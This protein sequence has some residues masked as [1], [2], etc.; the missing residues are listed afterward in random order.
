[1][2]VTVAQ[3]VTAALD[4]TVNA[5]E[6]ARLVDES[7]ARLVVFP[8]LSITGYELSADP[9]D[10]NDRRLD[11]ITAACE[12]AGAVALVGAPVCEDG[13]RF[14]AMLR[15]DGDGSEIV[16]RKQFVGGDE[17]S[18]F[19]SGRETGVLRLDG[20]RIG[21]GICKDTGSARHIAAMVRAGIDLYVA[22]VVHHSYERDEQEA[23]ALVIARACGASV[24]FAS[25]AGPT[26]GGYTDPLGCSSIWTREGAAIASVDDQ[27]GRLATADLVADGG[28]AG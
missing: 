3:P 12:R 22:G 17:P 13:E 4:V 23:R 15:V 24:A 7:R 28:I 1:M 25:H 2:R 26:G 21:L 16:Y 27:P 11:P 9:I 19:T 18:Y 14:I 10:P 6:H 20:W 8:E 5:L